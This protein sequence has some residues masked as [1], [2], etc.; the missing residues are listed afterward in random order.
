MITLI[1]FI[2]FV[3]LDNLLCGASM[4]CLSMLMGLSERYLFD[5]ELILEFKASLWWVDAVVPYDDD[6]HSDVFPSCN[7]N[8]GVSWNNVNEPEMAETQRHSAMQNATV[9]NEARVANRYN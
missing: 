8:L 2:G 4:L 3:Q 6:E 9:A 7:D 1:Y 5:K